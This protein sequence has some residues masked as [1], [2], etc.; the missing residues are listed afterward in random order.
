M[1]DHYE[2]RQEIMRKIYEIR[3]LILLEQ[4]NTPSTKG[5][6]NEIF[7]A[8]RDGHKSDDL[9]YIRICFSIIL[10]HIIHLS[11]KCNLNG[12]DERLL[13]SMKML[14]DAFEKGTDTA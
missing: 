7:K 13:G 11:E 2:N 12:D 10:D 1:N 6:L 4:S 5:H 3:N 8:I 14:Q 9:N